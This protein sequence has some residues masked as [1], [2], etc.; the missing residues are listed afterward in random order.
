ML[1]FFISICVKNIFGTIF[2]FYTE[3]EGRKK[4]QVSDLNNNLLNMV[5]GQSSLKE[6]G[7]GNNRFVDLLHLSEKAQPLA[8]KE[9]IEVSKPKEFT[10][11]LSQAEVKKPDQNMDRSASPEKEQEVPSQEN[12]AEQPEQNKPEQKKEA[13]Q[14]KNATET[15][16]K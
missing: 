11:Q 8:E 6:E 2:A 12:K 1:L 15:K 7:Q 4:M 10:V 9:P 16:D 5:T 3:I 13:P 14:A